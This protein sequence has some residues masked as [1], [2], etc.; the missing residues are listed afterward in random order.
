MYKY[1]YPPPCL[2]GTKGVVIVPYLLS[3][4]RPL[5][6]R[7]SAPARDEVMM[8]ISREPPQPASTRWARVTFSAFFSVRFSDP[9]REAQKNAKVAQMKPKGKQK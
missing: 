4:P 6:L 2:E 9:F 3:F 1:N 8:D 7:G 5:V